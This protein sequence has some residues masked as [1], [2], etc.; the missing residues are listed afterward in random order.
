M[1]RN[2]NGFLIWDK[3]FEKEMFTSKEIA[4][5]EK[6]LKLNEIILQKRDNGEITELEFN[7]MSIELDH[8]H[9]RACSELYD[10]EHGVN[11]DEKCEIDEWLEKLDKIIAERNA[12]KIT[13]TEYW[14]RCFELDKKYF[15]ADEDDAKLYLGDTKTGETD[16]NFDEENNFIGQVAVNF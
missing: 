15:L 11:P 12:N 1:N 3:D 9:T 2:E 16:S 14:Q 13:V 4:I 10:E 5:S 7:R 6:F 8:E